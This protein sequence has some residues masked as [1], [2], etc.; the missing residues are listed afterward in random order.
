[1]EKMIPDLALRTAKIHFSGRF[2]D[3]GEDERRPRIQKSSADGIP[4]GF[5]GFQRKRLALEI[6]PYSFQD[7]G[8][9]R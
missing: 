8:Q 7:Q 9:N 1:M 5:S 4:Y 2:P 3:F 6:F